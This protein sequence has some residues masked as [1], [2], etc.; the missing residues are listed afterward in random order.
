[1]ALTEG[2]RADEI[3]IGGR[4]R[5]A[6]IACTASSL[7]CDG[8]EGVNPATRREAP[9]TAIAAQAFGPKRS[10]RSC[11]FRNVPHGPIARKLGL[12]GATLVRRGRPQGVALERAMSETPTGGR[13]AMGTVR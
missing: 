6:L 10:M 13:F 5:T 7:G 3:E 4:C 2:G 8:C 1:M 12:M 9:L 11:I